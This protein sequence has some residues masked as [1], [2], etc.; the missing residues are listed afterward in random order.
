MA[1]NPEIADICAWR[2]LPWWVS[3]TAVEAAALVRDATMPAVVR[4]ALA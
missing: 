3:L 1:P 2:Y 4:L